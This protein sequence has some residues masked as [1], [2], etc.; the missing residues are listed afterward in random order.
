[1]CRVVVVQ[2]FFFWSLFKIIF[3]RS[4]MPRG[5]CLTEKEV[6]TFLS[7]LYCLIVFACN[8]PYKHYFLL[9]PSFFFSFLLIFSSA[10]YRSGLFLSYIRP[11]FS[12]VA[13]FEHGCELRE[14]TTALIFI[15]PCKPEQS[16]PAYNV[17]PTHS[18]T[19]VLFPID[20]AP[21]H[22]PPTCTTNP[23]AGRL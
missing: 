12:L 8:M 11:S 9:F 18:P 16:I 4:G 23:Q 7:N 20:L 21:A 14:W 17:W 3:R 1:M 2:T 5:L 15:P 6:R 10:I 22:E 19:F 13:G